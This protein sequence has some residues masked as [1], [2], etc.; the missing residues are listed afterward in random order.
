[1]PQIPDLLFKASPY[2]TLGIIMELIVIFIKDGTLSKRYSY[3]DS[4]GSVTAGSVMRLGRTFI[5]GLE[6][7]LY[8]AVYNKVS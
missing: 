7:A 8:A 5:L 3:S 4:I 1:M 6:V 2:F